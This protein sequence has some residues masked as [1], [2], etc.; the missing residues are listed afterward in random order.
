MNVPT[1]VLVPAEESLG[2]GPWSCEGLVETIQE[3]GESGESLLV[4]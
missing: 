3:S 4:L 1:A 2:R